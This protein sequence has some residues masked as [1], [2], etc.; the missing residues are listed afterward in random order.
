MKPKYNIWDVLYPFVLSKCNPRGAVISITA[1]ESTYRTD[2]YYK[3]KNS[4]K[5]FRESEIWTKQEYK[6]Y[7]LEKSKELITLANNLEKNAN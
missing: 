6:E 4:N 7:L 2:F 1:E 3:I 5:N